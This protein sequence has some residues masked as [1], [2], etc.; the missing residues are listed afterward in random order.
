MMRLEGWRMVVWSSRVLPAMVRRLDF[1]L[2]AVK[3]AIV[4]DSSPGCVCWAGEWEDVGSGDGVGR[5]ADY[6]VGYIRR[7][8]KSRIKDNFQI[9]G[10]SS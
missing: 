10:L 2:I 3:E 6:M 7:G 4:K 5:V 9:W 8:G 1:S